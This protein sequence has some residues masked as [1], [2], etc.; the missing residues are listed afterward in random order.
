MAG[1]PEDHAAIERDQGIADR[2]LMDTNRAKCPVLHWTWNNPILASVQVMQLENSFPEKHLSF[3]VDR[4][5][6]GDNN[7]PLK[8]RMTVSTTALALIFPKFSEIS[9]IY[10]TK[11]QPW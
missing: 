5:L 11:S 8:L 3:L 2:N 10:L 6:I 9:V 4:Q 1:K 7:A